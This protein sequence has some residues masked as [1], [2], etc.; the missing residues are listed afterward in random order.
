MGIL[1][2]SLNSHCSSPEDLSVCGQQRPHRRVMPF[3]PPPPPPPPPSPARRA[4]RR[5]GAG[6]A[7]A[8]APH[9]SAASPPPPPPP[10][11]GVQAVDRWGELE[12]VAAALALN[13]M[14]AQKKT[15]R[16]EPHYSCHEEGPHWT[17]RVWTAAGQQ[18]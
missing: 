15:Q 7:G 3:A 11:T 5:R 1:C 14:P 6:A 12:G 13:D 9:R 2:K 18:L 8:G 16:S 17:T 10:Y 4:A